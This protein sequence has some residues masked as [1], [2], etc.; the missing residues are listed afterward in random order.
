MLQS[1]QIIDLILEPVLL[2]DQ[3]IGRNQIQWIR[4]CNPHPIAQVSG[5]LGGMGEI[6]GNRGNRITARATIQSF[7]LL[8]DRIGANITRPAMPAES[9][10]SRDRRAE[11]VAHFA[12]PGQGMQG[13]MDARDGLDPQH[14][15][16]GSQDLVHRL[17]PGDT[18]AVA[19]ARERTARVYAWS[20]QPHPKGTGYELPN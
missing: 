12:L 13:E 20:L 7:E 10:S 16:A 6:P 15:P 2:L 1:L 4:N 14:R 3:Y 11:S 8:T 17:R 9:R 18:G 19:R 5:T